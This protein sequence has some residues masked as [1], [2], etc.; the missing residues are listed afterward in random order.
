M[1]V[2][3]ISANTLRVPYYI[4]PLGLDY[5]A[6]AIA[7]RHNVMIVDSNI[8]KG[9]ERITGTIRDFKPDAIGISLRNIDN[10]NLTDSKGYI[11]AY[12][13]L[14]S[15]IRKCTDVPIILGGSGFTL[16]PE[17][18]MGLLGAD[19]GIIGEGERLPRLLEAL[20]RGDD[21][22]GLPGVITGSMEGSFP[23]PL[24]EDF[25]RAPLQ[26]QIA[27][28][29]IE[30]G[31]MLNLQTKRGCP[32]RCI[33]C[34]YPHIEGCDLRPVHPEEVADT[35]MDLER[36]GANY[37]Y[38]TDSVFNA[39]YDQSSRVARAFMKAGLGIPWGAFLSPTKPPPGYYALLRDAGM[40]H[41]EF[42][43][44]SLSPSMLASYRKPFSV[45]D[46]HEA[47]DA[48]VAAGL[49]VCHYLLLG[50]PGENRET[51]EET[52]NNA[53]R[54]ER[55]VIFFFCGIRIY[56]HTALYDIALREG[57]ISGNDDLIKPVF[58]QS[59]EIS[60]EEIIRITTERAAGRENWFIGTGSSLTTRL[61]AR[62]HR[63]GHTGPLWEMMIR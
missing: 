12:R 6:R 15:A 5:V 23:P 38:I 60:G 9:P 30:R 18:L 39:D 20:E 55:T 59:R 49:Y 36:A 13:K 51:L 46:V 50:G 56:P 3:L 1:K 10:T 54:L 41:A 34:T 16:F 26:Q 45:D 21:P 24:D 62:L 47:H 17:Q 37:L 61:V 33:Y 53:A 35:A 8:T 52:L 44:E 2:L 11:D 25:H 29:Y 4:Y 48:A 43:T 42:G 58:Y 32:Y 57:Q 28:F 7:D 19:Y 22:A 27:R 40:T 14:V 63:Q 31:G